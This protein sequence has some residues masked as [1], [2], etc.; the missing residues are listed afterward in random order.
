MC[1]L[2]T[3]AEKQT[4][5]HNGR[6]SRLLLFYRDF[7]KRG[8]LTERSLMRGSATAPCPGYTRLDMGTCFDACKWFSIVRKGEKYLRI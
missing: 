1:S 2:V 4:Y 3:K 5:F 8:H 6:K 7:T